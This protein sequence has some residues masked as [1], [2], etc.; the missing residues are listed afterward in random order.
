MLWS[1]T[2]GERLTNHGENGL[3]LSEWDL[4]EEQN[5]R[6]QKYEGKV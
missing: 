4:T 1:R 2:E 6:R 3:N 5:Q